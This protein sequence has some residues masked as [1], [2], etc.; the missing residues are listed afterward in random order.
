MN[1]AGKNKNKIIQKCFDNIYCDKGL[2]GSSLGIEHFYMITSLF[3]HNMCYFETH[4]Q[5]V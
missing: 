5:L 1:D 2:E 3:I 4:V